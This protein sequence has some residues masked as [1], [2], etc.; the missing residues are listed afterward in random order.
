MIPI[1]PGALHPRHPLPLVHAFALTLLIGALAWGALAFGGVYSWAY[2][3][4]AIVCQAVGL[5]GI[6]SE[7]RRAD[8][9]NRAL[10]VAFLIAGGAIM[11]QLVPLPFTAISTL[12]PSTPGLVE[13]LRPS[14]GTYLA[15]SPLS[16]QPPLTSRALVLF[17]SFALLL[18]GTARLASLGTARVMIGGISVLGLVLALAGI[19]QHATFNGRIY[20]IWTS[21]MGGTPFGPF[22]N[23][24]H[25]AGWML[26]AIPLSLGL[27][28]ADLARGMRGVKP[29][30]RDRVLWLASADANRLILLAG[31]ITVMSLSLVLTLSRSGIVSL[32]LVL[33]LVGWFALK[34]STSR[35]KKAAAGAYVVL[36]AL[37]VVGLVGTE[38]IASRF[39]AADW[40]ELNER[41]GA[42]AD[43]WRIA[44]TFPVAGTGLNTYGT[45]TL[46]FQQY[47]LDQH[48]VQAHNDYLQLAAEGGLLVVIPA[49]VCAGLF[50]RDV[51][52]RFHED[53]GSSSYWLRAGAV[54][55]VLAMALQETVEFS[56][57]MPGNAALFAVV[58]GIALHKPARGVGSRKLAVGSR[59]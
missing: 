38:V 56:L 50:A 52:R 43:A 54:A 12:S 42:W 20:G 19:V 45:A 4:L 24:N 59:Q 2:W 13:Q 17:T 7:R 22:V 44:S 35:L 36:L 8:G 46:F 26:L 11:A 31:A 29:A 21:E 57:Q 5:L 30:W 40:S 6:A 58:C 25:F 39:A 55:A 16:I 34:V 3:P 18:F 15:A 9:G 41:R 47:D 28:C 53:G 48:Y 51:R 27:L 10:R 1:T 14:L 23:R 32:S 33:A 37:L 49:L